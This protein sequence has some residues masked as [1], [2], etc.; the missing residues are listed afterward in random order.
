MQEKEINLIDLWNILWSRRKLI[1]IVVMI[2]SLIAAG[3]SFLLPKVYKAT[4]VIMPPESSTTSFS[5]IGAG[6]SAFGLGNI[7][8][9]DSNQM[10]ILAI[11]KS[12]NILVALDEKY[13]FQSK[14]NT[15]FKFQTYK[16]LKSNLRT[17]VGEEEQIIISFFDTEQDIVAEIVNYVVHCLDSL[18]ITFSTSKAK[19]N[20]IFIEK[21]IASVKDSL[22]YLENELSVYM[23]EKGIISITDQLSAAVEKAAELQ[24]KITTK[25]IELEIKKD[26]FSIN[27]PEI[28]ILEKELNLLKD[29]FTT[30]F[31]SEHNELFINFDDV[32]NLQMEL[33]QLKRRAEYYKLMLEY[34]TPQYEQAK[35][36]EVKDIPTIQVLDKAKRP[37]WKSKPKRAKFVLIFFVISLII[38]SYVALLTKKK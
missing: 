3:I 38:S 5:G 20:R 8:G 12:K 23:E 1:I 26:N 18:N 11:L 16:K 21:R 13:D 22:F 24:A 31:T 4:A 33:L 34:L 15:K 17:E 32:P 25:E 14:Y 30:F 35:I 36:E 27:R 7:L 10:R 2:V 29:K 6:L 37:E 9:G 19:N 28:E